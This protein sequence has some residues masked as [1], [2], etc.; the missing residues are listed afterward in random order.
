MA[1]SDAPQSG[2]G[3]GTTITCCIRVRAAPIRYPGFSHFGPKQ[4]LDLAALFGP[5]GLACARTIE[6]TTGSGLE[7]FES[8]ITAANVQ[9]RPGDFQFIHL[10]GL[11]IGNPRCDINCAQKPDVG[12]EHT[13]AA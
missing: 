8:Q 6:T 2:A 13:K 7:Q 9:Y 4:R 5:L 12:R 1:E 11:T 3:I 10:K